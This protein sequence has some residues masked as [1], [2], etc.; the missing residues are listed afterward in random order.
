MVQQGSVDW[1]VLANSS[2]T[3]SVAM[4]NRI[5]KANID[6]LTI[7][8]AQTMFSP[9]NFQANGQKRLHES[10]S[11]LKAFSSTS[12]LLWFGIGLKHVVRSLADTEQ[13][14]CCV[15]ICA[16][17]S[18]SYNSFI[19]GQILKDIC[20]NSHIP[21][22]YRPSLT[23]WAALFDVC[24]G[25]VAASQF[26]W[27]V[28][29]FTTILV[30]PEMRRTASL[31]GAGPPAAIAAALLDLAKISRGTLRHIV[32]RGSIDCA[33]L[34]TVAE[35][36]LSL[37]VEV[38]DAS[39]TCLYRSEQEP[40]GV[41]YPQVTL[42]ANSSRDTEPSL[43][44]S[45][46]Q[47][48][49]HLLPDGLSLF[50]LPSRQNYNPFLRGRSTWSGILHDTFGTLFDRLLEP[51]NIGS[52]ARRLCANLTDYPELSYSVISQAGLPRSQNKRQRNKALITY[53]I[54]RLPE[55][56]KLQEVG[57]DE[58][59]R[60]ADGAN[61][62][63]DCGMCSKRPKP[64]NYG[65]F[66]LGQIVRIIFKFLY[67]LSWLNIE[68][69]VTPSSSGLL[70]FYM[71]DRNHVIPPFDPGSN[72]YH[73][74]IFRRGVTSIL[75]LFTGFQVSTQSSTG[76]VS[77]ICGNGICI[78]TPSL[79][80]LGGDLLDQLQ[81]R[82]VTGHIEY[83]QRLY[84][85]IR[86]F[87]RA[88]SFDQTVGY[89]GTGQ[90]SRQLNDPSTTMETREVAD[91]PG[92]DP[93]SRY[94]KDLLAFIRIYG[95]AP[96][97]QLLVEETMDLHSL[98][99]AIFLPRKSPLKQGITTNHKY[100]IELTGAL[101][102]C[103]S[104]RHHV[105]S[106]NS[107]PTEALEVPL[108]WPSSTQPQIWSGRCSLS[109][110]GMWTH[111]PV[112]TNTEDIIPA[113]DDWILVN[114]EDWTPEGWTPSTTTSPTRRHYFQYIKGSIQ[115]LYGLLMSS[116]MGGGG[117]H[118]IVP[119]SSCLYCLVSSSV[120]FEDGWKSQPATL[121][122]AR[123]DGITQIKLSAEISRVEMGR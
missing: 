65:V 23:Q 44:M 45:L 11:K 33:W 88:D 76:M 4:L 48:R 69:S 64:E 90:A 123:D 113:T 63:C 70:W 25:A 108:I 102:L 40:H 19:G 5:S 98:N 119:A 116:M 83:C 115:F 77:A 9:F 55:L 30:A 122:V 62:D 47:S 35:W 95:T 2:F 21:S 81:F 57:D 43:S 60:L 117:R 10:L 120:T 80:E 97:F 46:I 54:T 105:L 112:H 74:W 118:Y 42:I 73:L 96:V 92:E 86:D 52:F 61:L 71:N 13:G 20:D 94:T 68:D 72:P 6:A 41:S 107:C 59:E 53:A 34:G 17:L 87:L 32:L 101:K 78:Y 50:K 114:L 24:A 82:V 16:C 75:P 29:G 79:A 37:R 89:S 100:G 109:E 14:A 85:T 3:F 26:P 31:P 93:D 7:A 39:G 18:V 104:L 106:R 22:N 51:K 66:C 111:K 15:A 8:V 67:T 103:L 1:G 12:N 58:F 121:H 91:Y 36:L 49:T 56:Q 99:M 28:E 84:K 38:L 27:K 110:V